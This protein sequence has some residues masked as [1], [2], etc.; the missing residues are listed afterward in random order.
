MMK[1]R[2]IA[3]RKRHKRIL[4]HARM[5]RKLY[6]TADLGLVDDVPQGVTVVW[7]AGQRL[8]VQHELTARRTS[9][10]GD[11]RDLDAELVRRAGLALANTLGLGGM[12]GIELPAALALLLASLFTD[13]YRV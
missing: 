10:G 9:V 5:R 12:E 11:D 8:G 13:D 6:P 1:A 7:V 3:I 2:R 4:S